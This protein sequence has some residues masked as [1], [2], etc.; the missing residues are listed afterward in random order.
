[1]TLRRTADATRI[2]KK[3]KTLEGVGYV[4]T[5]DDSLELITQAIE[6]FYSDPAAQAHASSS[7]GGKDRSKGLGDVWEKFKGEVTLA[8]FRGS[9]S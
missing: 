1:L 8:R 9:R 7:G 3:H 2:L 6:A 4:S 5:E